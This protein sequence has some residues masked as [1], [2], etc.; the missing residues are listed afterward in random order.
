MNESDLLKRNPNMR[1]LFISICACLFFACS[2]NPQ[3]VVEINTSDWIRKDKE[4][5]YIRHTFSGFNDGLIRSTS[6]YNSSRIEILERKLEN[7]VFSGPVKLLDFDSTTPC[8]EMVYRPA[9]SLI[10]FSYAY[11]DLYNGIDRHYCDGST[12]NNSYKVRLKIMKWNDGSAAEFKAEVDTIAFLEELKKSRFH[13][14][15]NGIAIDS[16]FETL[17]V[18]KACFS[19]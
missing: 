9:D 15:R 6:K 10:Y 7:G 13:G 4:L 3:T 12:S 8:G 5:V 14:E 1:H 19:F 17:C 16:L 11:Q 2:E 18:G